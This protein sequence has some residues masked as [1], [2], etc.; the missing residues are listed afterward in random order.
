MRVTHISLKP[1]CIDEITNYK[2]NLP[3]QIETKKLKNENAIR[4]FG[5]LLKS[6]FFN[7]TTKNGLPK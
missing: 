4:V 7:Y 5:I 3:I 1:L 2:L 6:N